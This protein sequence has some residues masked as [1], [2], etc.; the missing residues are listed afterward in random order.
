MTVPL[1]HSDVP[2]A[3]EIVKE[4]RGEVE[5]WF[6]LALFDSS[7]EQLGRILSLLLLDR[8]ETLLPVELMPYSAPRATIL[9][10]GGIR[11]GRGFFLPAWALGEIDRLAGV[12][13]REQREYLVDM[14]LALHQQ[15]S[16]RFRVPERGFVFKEHLKG[17]RIAPPPQSPPIDLSASDRV[18]QKA[19]WHQLIA[20][21]YRLNRY[22]LHATADQLAQ[23]LESIVGNIHS[24]DANGLVS[25]DP[26]N[27]HLFYWLARLKEVQTEMALRHGPYPAGW[28][29]GM[30]DFGRM[31]SSLLSSGPTGAVALCSELGLPEDYL[32]KYGKR[33]YIVP[34]RQDGLLRISPATSYSDPSLNPAVRDDELTAQ[35]WY[36]PFAPY[37]PAPPGTVLLPKGRVPFQKTLETNYYVYC[38]SESLERRLLFDFESDA[39]LVIHDPDALLGR[40]VSAARKQLPGWRV[41]FVRVEY[42][43]PFTFNPWEIKLGRVKDFRYAYQQE[44][45][46]V[47]W[48][49]VTKRDLPHRFLRVGTLSDISEL[50]VPSTIPAK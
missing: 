23:R 37:S 33:Q 4:D 40:V 22:L 8:E 7:L 11:R 45:R 50:I 17:A 44:V 47:W 13:L 26:E 19:S 16:Q 1:A 32:V 31:P 9:K 20:L 15:P 5:L 12:L 25:L 41:E 39:A 18:T 24:L 34:M 27:P 10:D 35:I 14:S 30:I 28:R 46:L 38:L 3:A 2:I 21:D 29:R 36:D 43:D 49:P 6:V 48:P 42:F